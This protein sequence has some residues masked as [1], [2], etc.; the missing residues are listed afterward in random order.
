[1]TGPMF[2]LHMMLAAI[3]LVSPG[4]NQVVALVP[5]CQRAMLTNRTLS[6]RMAA[7]KADNKSGKALRHAKEWR[8]SK[9]VVFEWRATDGEKGPWEILVSKNP[10]LTNAQAVLFRDKQPDPA[11]GRDVESDS[12]GGLFRR[13]ERRNA[14]RDRQV[15][16]HHADGRSIQAVNRRDKDNLGGGKS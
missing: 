14:V 15:Q 6:A 7:L 2:G 9:P 12:G 8:M 4:N 5:D 11:T 10:D 16:V 1:M 3:E 13:E